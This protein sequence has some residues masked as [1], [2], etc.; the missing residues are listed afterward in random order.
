[1]SGGE[2]PH[3]VDRWMRY[4]LED[5]DTAN[6]IAHSPDIVPRQACWFAQQSAEK[7]IKSI[8]VFLE[9]RFPYHH[10]LKRLLTLVPDDWPVKHNHPEVAWL[11]VWATAARYPA[12]A[13]EPT[14]ADATKALDLA[15]AIVDDIRAE[16]IRRGADLG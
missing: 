1:M 2:Q 16:L 13:V 6:L 7:A 15:T 12:D 3:Q 14:V 9:I 5:L 10:D 4:A 11:T 8:L